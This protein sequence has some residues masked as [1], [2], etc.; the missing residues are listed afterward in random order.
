MEQFQ[1]DAILGEA[2][3]TRDMRESINMKINHHQRTRP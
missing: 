1:E 2:I 3:S